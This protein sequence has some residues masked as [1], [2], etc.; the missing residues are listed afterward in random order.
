MKLVTTFAALEL[1]GPDYRWK[2]AAYLDGPLDAGVLHGNLVLKG[3]GDPKITIEQWQAFMAM[4]R[5]KGLASVDGDLVLDRTFFAPVAHDPARL[6][7]RA[8][9]A[10]QRRAGRAARQFQV[11][12]VRLRARRRRPTPVATVEPALSRSR[13]RRRRRRS[14]AGDCG[15]WRTTLGATFV[16]HGTR[17][18]VSLRRAAIPAA[19]GERDWW[20]S[21]LDHPTYVHGMFD[22]Y[23]RAAGGRFAGGWRER[24]RAGAARSPFATLESP[25]L[26][27]VVRDVNKLSN[28]VMARQLFLTLA[29][30]N[31]PPPAT[32]ARATEA[33]HRRGSRGATSRCPS[34]CSTTAPACRARERI[35]AGSLARLLDRRRREPR[36]RG[37]RELARGRRDGRHGAAPLPERAPSR[38]R[39]CSRPE[40]STAC[41][42]SRAT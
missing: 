42:R 19:C 17:A 25:P 11:G 24:R 14:R 33:V 36:A 39:R 18:E 6:R 13:G 4:L 37:V 31:A 7:R 23:F 9:Q 34:S 1:L 41:A 27:D 35:S 10:L 21:L 22:T 32:T 3:G 5:D 38:A 26:W 40:R 16:D 30:A 20:V 8:A 28:N 29:T 15:D 12:A 2:T